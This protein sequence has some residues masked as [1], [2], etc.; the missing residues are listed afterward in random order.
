MRDVLLVCLADSRGLFSQVEDT[1]TRVT[2]SL[3]DQSRSVHAD[4]GAA[5][6]RI[7]ERVMCASSSHAPRLISAFAFPGPPRYG[8]HTPL[9]VPT[10]KARER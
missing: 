2:Y 9:P 5:A 3:E 1:Y 6:K 8:P 10:C 7:M 4:A